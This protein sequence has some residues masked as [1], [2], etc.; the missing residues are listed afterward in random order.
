MEAKRF[1]NFTTQAFTWKFD[2]VPYTFEAGQEIFLEDFKAEHF[3]KHLV[4]A[5][6]NRQGKPTNDPSRKTL[7]AQ[8]FPVAEPVSA[9]EALNLNEEAKAKKP[10]KKEAEFEDL[11]VK[12]RTKV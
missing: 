1:K 5:E 9:V 3:C 11:N 4:D 6:L 2:G 12:P 7:E 10:K 8:C